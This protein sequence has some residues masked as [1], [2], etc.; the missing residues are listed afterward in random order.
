MNSTI[1]NIVVVT[2]GLIA[3]AVVFIVI[4]GAIGNLVEK[5]T[6][7][8]TISSEPTKEAYENTARNG[9]ISGCTETGDATTQE[10]TCA[11][12]SLNTLYGESWW[13]DSSGNSAITNRILADGLNTTETDA[14]TPCITPHSPIK[15]EE[16]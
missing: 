11:W 7:N 8:D 9:F 10:C 2:V 13:G 3:A 4:V 6:I 12:N 16:I 1:K 5:T 15:T 14:M